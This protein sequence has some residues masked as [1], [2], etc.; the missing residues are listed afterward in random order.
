[1]TGKP[2]ILVVDDEPS[3][4]LTISANL[5]LE[6]FEVVEATDGAR[7]L[8]L[9]RQG[10]FDLVL[11]DIRMPG[12]SGVDLFHELRRSHADMPVVLMTAFALEG[13]VDQALR[14]GAFAVLSK[15][16]RIEH[17]V[18][19]L[20]SAARRPTVLVID[21]SQPVAE[22]TAAALSAVG[23]RAAAAVDGESA[24]RLARG[25]GVDICVVDMVMPGMD[26]A[27]VIEA[28]HRHDPG[29]LCIAVSGYDAQDLFRRV[30][31]HVQA[32][33]K[34]PFATGDL[35]HAIARARGKAR[36]A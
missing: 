22:S 1:M 18:A 10:P 9:T 20:S 17:M 3:L 23:V 8:E 30:A 32:I 14:D 13:L 21:D 24:L 35:A 26:G 33:L 5:E 4:L 27:Q 28:L 6:G 19:I 29:I 11:S 7:A 2:R 31:A 16:F 25:G 15:P 34:K 36:S 12:M